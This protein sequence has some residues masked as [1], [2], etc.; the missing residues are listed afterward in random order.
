M[1]PTGQCGPRGHHGPTGPTGWRGET[2]DYGPT[3]D[4]GATG[5]QGPTGDVGPTGEQGPTGDVGPTGE[6]GSTGDAGPTGEQ[7]STGDVGPTGQQGP[8]GDVGP[9]G[10]QGPTGELGPTGN[11]GPTGQTFEPAFLNAYSTSVQIVP[12]GGTVNFDIIRI[13]LGFTVLSPGTFEV[14]NDGWY[15]EIKTIDT[16][17]PNACALYRN[18]VL[19]PGTWF[20]A[21]ATAQ[22]IGQA[23][24]QLFSGDVIELRNES[25][26]GGTITLSPLGSGANPTVGQVT[27]ALSIFR[28]A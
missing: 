27:S 1:G 10:E 4:I 16:L 13:A 21:N 23:I 18:G 24:I 6:Q 17:E 19:V 5:E 14:L 28:I 3:G 12:L 15:Y 22:D 2:G 11:V 26:Q 9:T 8:T 7:G 25:S 20:G